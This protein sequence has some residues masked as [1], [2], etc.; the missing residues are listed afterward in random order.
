M[1]REVT[2]CLQYHR[3]AYGVWNLA[4]PCVLVAQCYGSCELSHYCWYCE[5]Y[6]F[7]KQQWL[8]QPCVCQKLEPYIPA[9]CQFPSTWFEQLEF[10]SDLLTSQWLREESTECLCFDLLQHV[11]FQR[12]LN[13]P[14]WNP[15]TFE[16]CARASHWI[17]EVAKDSWFCE[18]T[19]L[20]H[21]FNKILS[22]RISLR[23]RSR[24]T[25]FLNLCLD[26]PH[27]TSSTLQC[28]RDYLALEICWGTWRRHG[29]QDQLVSQCSYITVTPVLSE[30]MKYFDQNGEWE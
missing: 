25:H 9:V 15:R 11:Q 24:F 7:S 2:S 26:G 12:G 8:T 17:R 19:S 1:C 30:I 21:I 29:Q 22:M 10:L 3:R 20:E 4:P 23:L 6:K 16:E 13:D 5:K 18:C 28:H 14:V 27:K